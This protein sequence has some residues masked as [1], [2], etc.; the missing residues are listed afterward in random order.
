MAKSN[1]YDDMI[2]QS[3]Y[4]AMKCDTL[5][6]LNTN[7]LMAPECCD[8]KV[9]LLIPKIPF[10]KLDKHNNIDGD[11]FQKIKLYAAEHEQLTGIMSHNTSTENPLMFQSY[12]CS[13]LKAEHLWNNEL[14]ANETKKVEHSYI[15]LTIPNLQMKLDSMRT[16][17]KN[18]LADYVPLTLAGWTRKYMMKH[19]TQI[20][21]FKKLR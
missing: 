16:S 5:K 7:L 14:A 12:F 4:L 19:G 18:D 8:S 1:L 10:E 21:H 11:E 13:I 9:A 3:C 2:M 20:E 17:E 6:E 15:D